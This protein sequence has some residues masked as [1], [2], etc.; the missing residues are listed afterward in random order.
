MPGC[1][2]ADFAMAPP[3]PAAAAPAAGERPAAPE[4]AETARL[5]DPAPPAANRPQEIALKPEQM[6]GM[7][8]AEID[9][10]LGRPAFVR[11]EPPAEF[12]RYRTADCFLELYFYRRN[13]VDVLDH[14][15]FRRL[16][17]GGSDAECLA[18]V[19]RARKG[20]VREGRSRGRPGVPARGSLTG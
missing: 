16:G 8:R 18:S 13:N 15:E 12:R 1:R 9:G 19:L 20:P 11:R 5:P 17:G 7:T 14:V 2:L 4:P 10:L 6:L 3:P